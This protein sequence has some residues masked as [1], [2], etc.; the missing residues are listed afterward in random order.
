MWTTI[1]QKT[2]QNEFEIATAIFLLTTT[3]QATAQATGGSGVRRSH[4]RGGGGPHHHH[5]QDFMIFSLWQELPLL[6]NVESNLI[7]NNLC[8]MPNLTKLKQ[9]K[10]VER[11]HFFKKT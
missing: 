4:G 1:G 8:L 5:Q 6:V 9:Q 3:T 11:I 7:N 10:F 2:T